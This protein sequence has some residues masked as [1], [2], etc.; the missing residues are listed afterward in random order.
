MDTAAQEIGLLQEK[1]KASALPEKLTEVVLVRLNQLAKLT[2]SPTFLPEYDRINRF[3]EWI[4]KIPWDKKTQDNLDLVNAKKVLD[5]NHFGLG[6]IKDRVLEY[7]SVMRLNREGGG[8]GEI[9]RAPI[10]CFVGLVGT[11]KTTIASSIAESLGRSFARIPFGGMGDPLDLRGQSRMHAEAEPGKIIKSIVAA[12]NRN[13]VI[14]LDE[15]DRVTDEGRASIMGVLVELLDPE[16]NHEFVD[17]YIDYPVDLSE[18]LFIATANNTTNISTAVLDRIEP[19]AMP[20]YSDNEK[21]T[22]GTTYI[23]PKA[24]KAA[25][26]D[27]GVLTIDAEVWASIVRPLGYDAGIRTLERTIEGIVRKVARAI[28]EGKATNY[29]ITIQNVKEFLPQ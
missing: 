15:I 14:L 27:S 19:I 7:I 11:G 3:I 5:K 18:V 29:Q 22:I 23:L 8:P 13:P 16:Q 28:V 17:H 2:N 24:M 6:D 12:G 1:V 25:G 10:L 21:I 4:I 9:T 26:I 20:S